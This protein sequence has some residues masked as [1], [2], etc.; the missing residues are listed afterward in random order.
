[1]ITPELEK[2]LNFALRYPNQAE[3]IIKLIKRPEESQALRDLIASKP[4]AP[5]RN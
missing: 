1:M 5:T 2:A 4:S 3:A